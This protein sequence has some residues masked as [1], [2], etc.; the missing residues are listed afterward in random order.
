MTHFDVTPSLLDLL[1]LPDGKD[2]RFGLGISLFS[3]IS[4]EAYERHLQAVTDKSILNKS[5]TYEAFWKPRVPGDGGLRQTSAS[6]P[7]PSGKTRD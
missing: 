3:S 2:T 4:A 1:G 6:L 5:S 7:A